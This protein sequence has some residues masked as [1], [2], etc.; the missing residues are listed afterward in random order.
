MF[1]VVLF[2]LDGTLTESGI[3][4][5]R[6]VAYALRKHGIAASYS[7]MEKQCGCDVL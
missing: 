6:S 5:T 2:D 4:I 1:D 7:D 3:G